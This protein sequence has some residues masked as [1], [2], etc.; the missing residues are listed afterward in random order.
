[1]E[2]TSDG[3]KISDEDLKLRGPGDFFGTKQHGYIKSGLINFNQDG[4]IIKRARKKAF[5]IIDKDS[6]LL[7]SE[8]S[9]IRNQFM[10]N[11]KEMLEFINIG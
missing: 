9:L 8:N 3:F 7:L 11:Y 5:E 4:D 1:M 10:K 6:K 2:S